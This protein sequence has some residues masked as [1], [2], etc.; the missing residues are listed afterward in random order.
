ME[1]QN[2]I[3]LIQKVWT[4]S[5]ENN[6]SDAIGYNTL[7]YVKT[8]EEADK[9][10]EIGGTMESSSWPPIKKGENRIVYKELKEIDTI[11]WYE[12]QWKYVGTS[13]AIKTVYKD[14][15]TE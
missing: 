9:I 4:D 13:Q 15:T 3:Y 10:V 8:K 6:L 5:M 12:K 1:Q 7:G 14:G 2:R 11:E